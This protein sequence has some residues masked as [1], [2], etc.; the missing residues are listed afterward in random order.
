MTGV[1]DQM[2]HLL[3]HGDIDEP[4]GISTV[5]ACPDH[6]LTAGAAVDTAPLRW[7][8]DRGQPAGFV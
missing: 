2:A 8:S 7:L 5:L 1:Q 4:S 6:G 3:D